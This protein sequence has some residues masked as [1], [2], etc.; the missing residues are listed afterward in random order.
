MKNIIKI[1]MVLAVALTF[2]SCTVNQVFPGMHTDNKIDKVGKTS[3]KCVFNMCFG[4]AELG[5]IA[6]ARNGGISKIATVDHGIRGSFFSV[7]YETIV[8]GE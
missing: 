7:T 3:K 4:H 8:T 6:A 2:S 1:A 5:A